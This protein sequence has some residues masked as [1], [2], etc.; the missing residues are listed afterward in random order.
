[1][2]TDI[3]QYV[4][5]KQV[6]SYFLDE[7]NLSHDE[8]DKAWVLAF[9]ALVLLN[10]SIAAEPLTVRLPVDG[11]KTVTLP[12]DYLRW[13][14]IGILDNHGQISTLKVNTALTNYKD[15]SPARI[16]RLTADVNDSLPY[17]IG[18]PY[19]YNYGYNGV[20]Q[21]MFGVAGGGLVQYG[22]C[23]VD[24][25]NGVIIL[26]PEFRYDSVML[27]YISSPQKNNDY[28]IQ[29]VLQEAVIAFL[30]WKYK[31]G[32]RQDFYGAAIEGRRSLPGKRVT[33]QEVAQTIRS[34]YGMYVQ[35]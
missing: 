22:E 11:N 35:S 32:T 20:Y 8:L 7:N 27:E 30:N 13:S 24:E 26:S 9:R 10:Q 34:S 17:L 4:P 1:M 12:S 16:E 3:G 19:Y 5:L 18:S 25:K 21:T 28:E 14:K 6:V 23:V 29:T 15:N 2:S 33:L 31:F